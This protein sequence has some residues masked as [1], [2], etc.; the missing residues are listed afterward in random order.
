MYDD[1][2]CQVL[3]HAE[4]VFVCYHSVCHC[5]QHLWGCYFWMVLN[6]LTCMPSHLK[7]KEFYDCMHWSLH[8]WSVLN[9]GSIQPQIR[10][11]SLW[12][13]RWSLD[14][15][16]RDSFWATRFSRSADTCRMLAIGLALSQSWELR[17]PQREL[18]KTISVPPESCCFPK[19]NY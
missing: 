17:Y 1:W 5:E 4:H 6:I 13:V 19:L 15:V 16:S 12:C 18:L 9:L 3:E 8:V 7:S 11:M 2:R 14:E 10:A